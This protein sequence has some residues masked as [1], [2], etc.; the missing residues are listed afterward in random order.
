MLRTGVPQ[1]SV[2]GPQL[3]TLYSSPIEDIVRNYQVTGMYYADDSQL[4]IGLD[5]HNFSP[6]LNELETCISDIKDWT[7]D[8]KLALNDSKTEVVHITSRFSE[9][10]P[11]QSITVGDSIVYTVDQAKDL[12]IIIDQNLTMIPHVN[13]NVV[14]LLMLYGTLAAFANTCTVIVPNNPFMLSFPP[15][16]TL[17]TVSSMVSQSINL[18]NFNASRMQPPG[19][20]L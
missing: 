4:Y 11:L 18:T 3:F 20:L 12:G 13:S 17:T 1:G 15:V 2:A 5:P 6:T 7:A 10:T 19:L 8:N 9:T 16:W 14:L